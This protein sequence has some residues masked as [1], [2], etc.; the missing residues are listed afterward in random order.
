M[1]KFESYEY[2]LKDLE[3]NTGY[4]V[5]DQRTDAHGVKTPYIV[6][7]RVSN[8]DFHADNGILLKKD[9]IS[10]NL[11]TFQK[12]YSLNGE[13]VKAE[14]KLETYLSECGS[15]FD[16]DEDWLDDINLYRISYGLEICYD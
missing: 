13:K 5:Y 8:N 9:Q 6:C 11:H 16:R 12:N 15:L 1:K 14:K 7:Q 10:V 4:Q 2:F 3:E